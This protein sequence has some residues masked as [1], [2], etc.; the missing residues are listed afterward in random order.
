[1]SIDK[2]EINRL[3]TEYHLEIIRHK[4][5]RQAPNIILR[6]DG[7]KKLLMSMNKKIP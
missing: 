7:L 5:E 1:M 3:N 6:V 2:I 4:S